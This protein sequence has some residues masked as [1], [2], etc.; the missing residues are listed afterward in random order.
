MTNYKQIKITGIIGILAASLMYAGDMFLYFTTETISNFEEEI[1]KTLGEV[2]ITRLTIGGLI[3]PFAAFLYVIGFYQIYLAIKPS[4]KKMA[5]VIFVLLSLGIL[6]GGA[7]HSHF[8]YLGFIS[9]TNSAETLQLAEAYAKINSYLM[10]LPA[11]IAHIA[12]VF[13]IL[14]NKTYYPKWMVLFSPVV[15]LWFSGILQLLPQP[16]MII[17]AGGWNNIIFI[18][19]FSMSTITLLKK[20]KYE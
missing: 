13:L 9:S 18:L 11:I 1:I 12:L 2:S 14:K 10:I 3:G 7:F 19:L 17:I 16:F 5:K 4:H 20:K 8:T 6:Y 15:L